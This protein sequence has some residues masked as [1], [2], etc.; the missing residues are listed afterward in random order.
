MVCG[1]PLRTLARCLGRHLPAMFSAVPPIPVTSGLPTPLRRDRCTQAELPH[2]RFLKMYSRI[3]LLANT[4]H[5]R[6]PSSDLIAELILSSLYNPFKP[7]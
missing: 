6:L 1:F 5:E 3:L 7:K 2:S 4:L